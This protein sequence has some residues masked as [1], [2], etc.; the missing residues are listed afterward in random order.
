M[1]TH[2]G[3]IPEQVVN[4]ETGFL[5]PPADADAM[6]EAV[7]KLLGNERLRRDCAARAAELAKTRF[8]L[9]RMVDDYLEWYRH[10]I[11]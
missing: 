5:V 8:G 7:L 4:G 2:G 9:S 6:A 11:G 10:I 3:G 1:A